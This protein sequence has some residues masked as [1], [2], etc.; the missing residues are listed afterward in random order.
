[1]KSTNVMCNIVI[2]KRKRERG[3]PPNRYRHVC[4]AFLSL[5]NGVLFVLAWVA[6]VKYECGWHGWND[7]LDD[8]LLLLL[9]LLLKYYPEGK[10]YLLF[11]FETKIKAFSK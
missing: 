10:K 1:M 11:T 3:D 6:W 8:M 2:A 5:R 4:V 7:K 9:L